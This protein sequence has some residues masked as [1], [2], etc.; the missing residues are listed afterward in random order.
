M[1]YDLHD[2][3][4]RYPRNWNKLRYWIFER[5]GYRCRICGRSSNLVC[6]HIKPVGRG[7][8]HH[9]NNLITV[10]KPEPLL[11]YC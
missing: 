5:D 9:P 4:S 1:V 7:G 10:C 11:E 2:I 6:H 8:S 3:D